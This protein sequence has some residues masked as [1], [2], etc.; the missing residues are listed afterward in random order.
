[1]ASGAGEI[2]AVY[3]FIASHNAVDNLFELRNSMQNLLTEGV[4]GIGS[5][6]PT[7]CRAAFHSRTSSTLSLIFTL[8][9]TTVAF[10]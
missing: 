1:M 3:F 10:A 2:A 4:P 5:G 7:R 8:P 6:S 9:S